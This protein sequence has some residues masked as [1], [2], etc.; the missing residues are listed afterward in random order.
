VT[1]I[2]K[3]ELVTPPL[4]PE[5]TGLFENIVEWFIEHCG[6]LV[7]HSLSQRKRRRVRVAASRYPVGFWKKVIELAANFGTDAVL[8]VPFD[9]IGRDISTW[10]YQ[11]PNDLP[12]GL[13]HVEFRQDQPTGGGLG[14]TAT[15][16]GINVYTARFPSERVWLLSARMLR[17]IR[18]ARLPSGNLVDIAF[19]E[20]DDP[21]SSTLVESFAQQVEWN[22]LPIIELILRPSKASQAADAV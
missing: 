1:G 10:T 8:V 20:A 3:G 5:R 2:D 16:E 6:N 9:P 7:W 18:Y 15:I 11:N 4:S 21:R 17:S 14:Y 19:E 22:D 12:A 13:H